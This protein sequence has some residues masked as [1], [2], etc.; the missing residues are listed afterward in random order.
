MYTDL[1]QALSRSALPRAPVVEHADEI[2]L[3]LRHF[4]DVVIEK[5]RPHAQR[6]VRFAPGYAAGD[7]V[8]DGDA[9]D[10]K[11]VQAAGATWLL[12]RGGMLELELSPRFIEGALGIED[13]DAVSVVSDF[14]RLVIRWQA[15]DAE[16]ITSLEN[17][18]RTFGLEVDGALRWSKAF[19][20]EDAGLS[21]A[22]SLRQ[23]TPSPRGQRRL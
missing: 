13:A 6:L 15:L 20:Y 16:V 8:R 7:I 12:A 19:E 5:G 11:A 21:H 17:M 22:C 18:F 4:V 23:G 9:G 10:L 14:D 3:A 1:S 2:I